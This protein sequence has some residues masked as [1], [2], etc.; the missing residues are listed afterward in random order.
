MPRKLTPASSLDNLKKEAK[1]WLKELRAN[2][3][4]ARKRLER[5]W[6]KAPQQPGLRDVQHA[7][8]L[9]HGQQN[10]VALIRGIGS[11]AAS[12][13]SN[14]G[15]DY[16]A[17][18]RDLVAAYD[19]QDAAALQRLNQHYG[20]PFTY[21]DLS[22]DV[23][24]R[25]YAVRR[26]SS[27]EEKNFLRLTEAQTLLAQDAG[28]G[29]WEALKTAPTTGA[30]PVP[31][32]S[33]DSRK[34]HIAPRRF[35]SSDEWDQLAAVMEE[36][37]ITVVEG[38]GLVNDAALARIAEV[39]H[40]TALNLEGCR[41]V[42]DEGV[43]HLARMPQLERLNLGGTRIS[44]HGLEVLRHLPSLRVFQMPWAQ[45]V[46]DAGITSLQ[47]SSRL[48]RVDLT[49][50][51]T[52]DGTIA[53]LRGKSSLTH[54]R[55][56]QQV[57][58][59]GLEML[60]EFPGFTTPRSAAEVH[61]GLMSD[62][63]QDP[64]HLLI[65]G[66]F[67]DVGLA[68]LA[69]L[70]GL[71]GLVLFWH[72]QAFTPAAFYTL[73]AL[74]SL[75][76]LRCD[77]ERISDISMRYIA[78]MPRLRLLVTQGSAASDEGFEHLSRSRSLECFWGRECPGLGTR[79]FLA[80]SKMPSLRGLGVSCRNVD[81]RGLSSLPHFPAL[82]DFTP[83]D[84]ADEGFG[85]VGRCKHLER[86]W[87]MYCRETG[88]A[89]TEHISGLSLK[90]YYAGLTQITDYSLEILGKM[91]SIEEIEFY[92]CDQVSDAGLGH[93]AALPRLREVK[94]HHLPK[95]SFAGTKVFPAAVHVEYS[96]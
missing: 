49:G 40:V 1:R 43:A 19:S 27:R 37:R 90:T 14:R 7:L 86:L 82:R 9:E 57:T 68:S 51:K 35:L 60:K 15:T 16:D 59:S 31:P 24:R 66:P 28:F 6:P 42:S 78:A 10:W 50:T 3:A 96:T 39:E 87:C 41:Q 63:D 25:V 91:T 32:Y 95:V 81:D 61:Y 89:A 84:F 5:A 94:L 52:G 76:S 64:T 11:S 44:D 21:D 54:F 36:R 65:D 4:T 45:G 83:I 46:S 92:E 53:V 48:E 55:S 58:D 22:A 20:W 72:A 80:L 18:A 69:K 29:S 73:A 74:P 8:A 62:A 33:I 85:H 23:W 56:G 67:S 47:P 88:D 30:C 38:R 71:C 75:L 79:G 2:D 93:L 12:A 77:G 34:G 13:S 70:E 17:L 26:R